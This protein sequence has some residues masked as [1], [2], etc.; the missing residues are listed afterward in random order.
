MHSRFPAPVTLIVATMFAIGC[1]ES[2]TDPRSPDPSFELVDPAQRTQ[3]FNSH[4]YGSFAVAAGGVIRS[5][6]ANFPG[7]PSSG[8]GFCVDGLWYNAQGKAT[9][10]SLTKPHPHCFSASATIEVVLE[11]ITACY[12]GAQEAATEPPAEEAPKEAEPAPAKEEEATKPG[13]CA[14]PIAPKGGVRTVL[15]LSTLT[16]KGFSLLV[17][18]VDLKDPTFGPDHT[19]GLGIVTAYAIDASTLGTTN[20]RVGTLRFDLSQYSS[21]TTSYLHLLKQPGCDIDGLIESP[22]LDKVITA[23]YNPLPPEQG[24]IGPLDTAVEGFLW[25]T[26]ASSPY[27][28]TD[29]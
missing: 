27:N 10:G 9:S 2:A 25:V 19:E 29:K 13:V 14:T 1:S 15:T 12:T 28:Y 26:P 22:C 5:G 4:V 17:D 24:G 18:A 11:P 20:K 3:Q 21:S 16:I 23:V 6:P 8:P 7:K